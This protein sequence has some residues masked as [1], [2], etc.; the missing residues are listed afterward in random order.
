MFQ[1]FFIP[2]GKT[3]DDVSGIAKT[4]VNPWVGTIISV[5]L[6]VGLG[7]SGYALIWP[8]F[9]AANQLL[10]ALG[11]LAVACFLGNMGR[12]NKMFYVPMVFMLVVTLSSLAITIQAK[13][14]IIFSGGLT[15]DNTAA[16]LIQFV[17]G[18]ILVILAILLAVKGFKT[19]FGKKQ[20][21]AA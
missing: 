1:E 2:A 18:I 4:L 19:I 7:L 11:L 21:A 16:T 15:A 10:A 17:L 9:G 5:V 3:A 8:L 13:G 14:A 6:G 20:S 12:N